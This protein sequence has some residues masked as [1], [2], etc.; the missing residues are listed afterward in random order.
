MCDDIF[1]FFW[2]IYLQE[3]IQDLMY[4]YNT[5]AKTESNSAREKREIKD[6]TKLTPCK[7]K[8]KTISCEN[9][10]CPLKKNIFFIVTQEELQIL[11]KEFCSLVGFRKLQ[12]QQSIESHKN[13]IPKKPEIID[14]ENNTSQSNDTQAEP[15]KVKRKNS[16]FA[17]DKNYFRMK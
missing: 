1:V 2:N 6:L 3:H 14:S 13:S 16:F 17:E 9:N 15:H 4:H 7:R 11:S 8:S 10:F 5:V 12:I